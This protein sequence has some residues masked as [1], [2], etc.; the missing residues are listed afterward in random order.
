MINNSP[1]EKMVAAERKPWE[2]PRVIA[3]WIGDTEAGINPTLETI[4]TL[5][6]HTS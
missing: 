6:G 2:T 5:N 4:D 3:G 1:E